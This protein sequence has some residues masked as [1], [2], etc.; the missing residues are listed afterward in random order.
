[1]SVFRTHLWPT[2]A[3]FAR[4]SGRLVVVLGLACSPEY[5]LLETVGGADM[6]GAPSVGGS[7]GSAEGGAM[8]VGGTGTAVAGAPFWGGTS[9][10]AG[11]SIGGTSAVGGASTSCATHA[12]CAT[13]TL[14][15]SN[16][17]TECAQVADT[18][19]DPC[20]FGFRRFHVTRNGCETCECVPPSEC[21]AASDCAG[22]EVCYAG[23]HCADG[24]ND[25]SC[26]SGNQCSPAGC[27]ALPATCLVFGCSGG[28]QCL[29]A[30]EGT[31]CECDGTSWLCQGTTGGVSVASCPQAC[32]PP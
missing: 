14:C 4:A 23:A 15:Q 11:A 28:G 21:T 13:G 26:C 5:A 32:A 9:A 2:P 8:G 17:C 20:D 3:S 7:A 22:G 12:E 31:T 1:M 18:C 29:A 16:Q 24:C 27:G 10:S 25:P 19:A 30:C 6:G